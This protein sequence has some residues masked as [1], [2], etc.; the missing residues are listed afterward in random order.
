MRMPGKIE[1]QDVKKCLKTYQWMNTGERQIVCLFKGHREAN[2]TKMACG[3]I[4]SGHPK[5]ASK[6]SG[7]CVH[8]LR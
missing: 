5:S 2:G 4:K 8:L 7:L 1:G 3:D 6:E